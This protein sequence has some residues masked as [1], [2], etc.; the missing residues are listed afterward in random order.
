[1]KTKKLKGVLT[2]EASYIVPIIF[3]VFIVSVEIAFYFHDKNII[4]GA[5]EETALYYRQ[6]MRRNESEEEAAIQYFQRR[7]QR[8]LIFFANADVEV[9]KENEYISIE[10]NA[11][12]KGCRV[13]VKRRAVITEPECFIRKQIHMK[14]IIKGKE[15]K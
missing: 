14:E 7:I 10:A 2:V 15:G 1:M 3:L 12:R 13:R 9:T 4:A 11:K 8:K 6:R 5:A